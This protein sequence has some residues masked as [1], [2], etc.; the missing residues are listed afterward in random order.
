MFAKFA[1]TLNPGSRRHWRLSLMVLALLVSSLLAEVVLTAA[2]AMAANFSS[3][4]FRRTWQQADY[5]VSI[6]AVQRGYTWGPE[7]FNSTFEPY[8]ESPNGQRRVEYLDKAR[9]EITQPNYTTTSDYY[10]TN[11]LLVKEM[12]LGA[13][14]TGDN[15]FAQRFPAYDIPVA[16]DPGNVNPEAATYASFYALNSFYNTIP[17]TTLPTTGLPLLEKQP[18]RTNERANETISKG[19]ATSRNDLL[20]SL[21]GTNYVLYETTL[22]HNIPKVF[23][24]YLNQSGQIFDGNRLVGGKVFNWVSTMGYPISDAYWTRAQVGGI[25]RDVLVQLYERRVLTYTPGNAEPFK[26]EMGNVGRHYYSWRYNAR[27]D[28]SL[29]QQS[30]TEV[31]PE[32]GFPGVSVSIRIFR[33]IQGENVQVTIN[34]PNGRPCEPDPG[35]GVLVNGVPTGFSFFAVTINTRGFVPGLYSVF[36][37]GLLSGNEAKAYFFVIGVPGFNLPPQ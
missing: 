16:G 12:V 28:L 27:Y 34:T 9:M 20:G 31:K 30:N 21:E 4:F 35:C 26:V 3:P 10:V 13:L 32:A 36:F 6:G 29:P 33:F 22:G 37:K 18:D 1:A 11:G 2:P 17:G 19:G 15:R 24:D 7:P 25:A 23:Y 5:P 8:L 14:Q